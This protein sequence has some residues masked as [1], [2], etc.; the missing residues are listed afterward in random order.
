MTI[1]EALR[2]VE[3]V[4]VAA[5]AAPV[6]HTVAAVLAKNADAQLAIYSVG[7][8]AD[9]DVGEFHLLSSLADLPAQDRSADSGDSQAEAVYFRLDG[10]GSGVLTATHPNA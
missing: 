8:P 5:D 1:A 3:S 10:A 9:Y 2:A 7:K 6:L 4:Y